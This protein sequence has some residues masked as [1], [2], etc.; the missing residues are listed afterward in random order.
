MHIT[1]HAEIDRTKSVGDLIEEGVDLSVSL[2]RHYAIPYNN[3]PEYGRFIISADRDIWRP[4]SVEQVYELD[5][6]GENL[7]S[8]DK[9]TKA[10]LGSRGWVPGVFAVRIVGEA[11]RTNTEY[12]H[13]L[14][15]ATRQEQDP[16][17][18]VGVGQVRKDS[19]RL[20]LSA[21]SLV[22]RRAF[23]GDVQSFEARA[24]IRPEV[25]APDELVAVSILPSEI[26]CQDFLQLHRNAMWNT[27]SEPV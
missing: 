7:R 6:I 23:L 25:D 1:T 12:T 14:D 18:E 19:R 5:E 11:G 20:A 17:F 10:T 3:Y 22:L 26:V 4:F 27:V 13:R 15:T 24:Y 9:T 2:Q 8:L 16:I 21:T